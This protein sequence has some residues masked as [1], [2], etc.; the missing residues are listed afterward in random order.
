MS[1]VDADIVAVTVYPG[2][3]RITRRGTVSLAA[4]ENRVVIGGLP[5]T[6]RADSVRAGGHGPATVLGVDVLPERNPRSPDV[7]VEE[8]ERRRDAVRD[9]VAELN[10]ED[11]VLAG[12]ADLI[13]A[14]ARRSGAAFARALAADSVEVSRVAAVSDGLAEQ[15]AAVLAARRQLTERRRATQQELDELER[16]LADRIAAQAPDRMAVAVSL[17]VAA[18]ADI[19]LE[20][21]YLVDAARWESRYDVRLRGE[22]LTLTWFGLVSQHT[23]EDWPECDLRLSTARPASAVTVPELDPWYLDREQPVVP[24]RAGFGMAADM[25]MERM[26]APVPAQAPGGGGFRQLVAQAKAEVATATASVE[27]GV[28]AATY[29]PARPVAVPADGSAHRT[30]VLQAELPARLDHVTVPLRGP[31]A[32]LRATVVNSSEHT[33]RPGPA[34]IFHETEFVGS[35]ALEPWAPGEEVEL[36]LGV[37]DRVRVERELV[38]RTAGKAVLGNTRRHEAA[39][40]ITIGNYGPRPASVTV[41]D[42][43]PVSRDDGITV[44]DVQLTPKPAEQTELGEVR[45]TLELAPNKTAELTMG[46]RVDVAKGVRLTGWRD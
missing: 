4:G 46:F 26:P 7:A 20:L 40:K 44:R 5:L 33:L 11:T 17:D 23:G 29:R 36:A 37:D 24:L 45:W 2:Q 41:I 39:Y 18:A 35:T 16:R 3:A 43:V 14:L 32:Y 19:E 31:E 42:Q 28:A 13:T 30:T 21:S 34:A 38:R 10:D 9:R 8:L 12:R 1:R 15:L 27:H 25:E 22:T 6:L